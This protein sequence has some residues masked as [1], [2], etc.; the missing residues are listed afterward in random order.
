MRSMIITLLLLALAVVIMFFGAYHLR[1]SCDEM[2]SMLE[3]MKDADDPMA[4]MCEMEEYWVK[5]TPLLHLVAP[6]SSIRRISEQMLSLKSCLMRVDTD[7]G[8]VIGDIT[9]SLLRDALLQLKQETLPHT[10]GELIS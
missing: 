4:L 7:S 10:I 9:Y 6:R 1:K 3:S 8:N 2:L 5:K